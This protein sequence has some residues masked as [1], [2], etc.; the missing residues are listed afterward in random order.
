MDK[1]NPDRNLSVENILQSSLEKLN[2]SNASDKVKAGAIQAAL[3]A[4]LEFQKQQGN[5]GELDRFNKA[6]KKKAEK[7]RNID[8]MHS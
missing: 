2:D 3:Q 6:S 7:A 8:E 1:I 5:P 4:I